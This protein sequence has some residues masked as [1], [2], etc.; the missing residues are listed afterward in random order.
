M[1][2]YDVYLHLHRI[3]Y[4]K[5]QKGRR[6]EMVKYLY[7]EHRRQ[8]GSVR[9]NYEWIQPHLQTILLVIK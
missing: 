6:T 5:S 8:Y 4:K 2:V 3:Y 7:E 9:G 1:F